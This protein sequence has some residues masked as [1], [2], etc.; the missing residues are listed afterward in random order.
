MSVLLSAQLAYVHLVSSSHPAKQVLRTAEGIC[1]NEDS[2]CAPHLGLLGSGLGYRA[3]P[4]CLGG[5]ALVHSLIYTQIPEGRGT[6]GQR[7]L[8]S[9]LE[10][11]WG[12][13]VDLADF[14]G[15]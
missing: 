13:Q 11:I 15:E 2:N 6:K 8:E 10:E 3:P 12:R 14:P 5:T 9:P 1:L 7:V 4:D